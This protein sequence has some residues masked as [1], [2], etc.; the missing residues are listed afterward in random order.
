MPYVPCKINRFMICITVVQK[1]VHLLFPMMPYHENIAHEAPPY[2]RSKL[3]G[4][5]YATFQVIHENIDICKSKLRICCCTQFLRVHFSV[6][7]EKIIFVNQLCQIQQVVTRLINFDIF[8]SLLQSIKAFIVRLYTHI[9]E[10]GDHIDS[11]QGGIL[12]N[13]SNIS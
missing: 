11:A 6:K 8:Q 3:A 10:K 5:K 1:Y 4:F 12:W 7:L 2:P 13:H 9:L